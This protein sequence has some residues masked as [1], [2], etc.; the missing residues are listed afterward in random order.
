MLLLSNFGR[1]CRDDVFAQVASERI[2]ERKALGSDRNERRQHERQSLGYT[3][4]AI[5]LRNRP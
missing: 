5:T 3:L 1:S 2:D 4:H